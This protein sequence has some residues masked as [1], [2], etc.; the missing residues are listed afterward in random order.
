[1]RGSLFRGVVLCLAGVAGCHDATRPQAAGKNKG[2]ER[3]TKQEVF[4]SAPDLLNAL[5]TQGD[6]SDRWLWVEKV[7][8][9]AAG[10]WATGRFDAPHNKLIVDTQDVEAFAIHMDLVPMDWTRLTIIR[11]DSRNS[12]LRKRDFSV[13]HFSRDEHGRWVV[14]EHLT[15]TSSPL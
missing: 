1:M 14:L 10:G 2:A 15:H 4:G 13:Y 6:N 8:D 5:E 9:R 11:I 3:V 7:R 12:E